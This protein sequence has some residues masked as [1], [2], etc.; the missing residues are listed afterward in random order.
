MVQTEALHVDPPLRS[1]VL[2]YLCAQFCLLRP[3]LKGRG[4]RFILVARAGGGGHQKNQLEVRKAEMKNNIEEKE[5]KLKEMKETVMMIQKLPSLC[6]PVEG[7]DAPNTT[8]NGEF[9]SESLKKKLCYLK[10]ILEEMSGW[11]F[12]KAKEAD[13]F[14]SFCSVPSDSCPLTLDPNTAHRRLRLS[15]GERKATTEM[16]EAPY[17]DHS[18]RFDFWLQVL[19][20][21]A[22]SGTRLYWEIEWSGEGVTVGLAYKGITRKGDKEEY[23][24]GYNDKSWNLFCS[25]SNYIAWHNTIKTEIIVRRSHRIGMYL[26]CPAGTLSFYSILDTMTL[27]YRFKATFTEPLY[28][29]FGFKFHSSVRI[30][31]LTP[32]GW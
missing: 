8:V 30:C 13:F 15:E 17:P 5:K 31:P 18:D 9:L 14:I 24:L 19:C 26:D 29:G 28:L 16:T 4:R 20:R 1:A 7:R 32:C 12:V 27:L 11:E 2:S 23:R 10:K 22:L 6:V 21:E 25:D 3:Q